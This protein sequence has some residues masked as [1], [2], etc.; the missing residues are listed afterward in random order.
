MTEEEIKRM[1]GTDLTEDLPESL[2]AV[3][4]LVLE[5]LAKRR[6][7]NAAYALTDAGASWRDCLVRELK[8]RLTELRQHVR[9]D[10]E[11]P[12]AQEDVAR[13]AASWVFLNFKVDGSYW[14]EELR[15]RSA[16]DPC[17]PWWPEEGEDFPFM[18]RVLTLLVWRNGLEAE[19]ERAR[20][21]DANGEW[22]LFV[23]SVDTNW[24]TY[25]LRV[26]GGYLY[27]C[28][29]GTA[30]GFAPDAPEGWAGK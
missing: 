16:P 15:R 18:L 19:A 22:E 17:A 1:W 5:R 2:Q 21:Y 20:Y 26:P 8:R 12:P 30:L 3:A 10:G 9:M 11:V 6:E 13:W 14:A 29:D 27:R 4:R 7:E 24:N 28:N 25:R 23:L